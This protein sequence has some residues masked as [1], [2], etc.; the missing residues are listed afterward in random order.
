MVN[1]E[2]IKILGIYDKW[3]Y[4]NVMHEAFPKNMALFDI[5][6]DVKENIDLTKISE[7]KEKYAAVLLG[8]LIPYDNVEP[9]SKIEDCNPSNGEIGRRVVRKLIENGVSVGIYDT[10]MNRNFET[11]Y[12]D[13]PNISMPKL[14][15]E[16]KNFIINKVLKGQAQFINQK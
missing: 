10:F 15:E 4:G 14:D 1:Q 3:V 11:L 9:K 16:V 8:L 2:N 5:D 12:R 13:I 7:I 6:I